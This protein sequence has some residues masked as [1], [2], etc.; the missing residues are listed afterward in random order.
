MGALKRTILYENHVKAGAN[1][2]DFGGWEMPVNYKLGMVEEHLYTRKK[3]GIFDVSHM[4]RFVI[5]GKEAVKFLQYVLTNNVFALDILRAQYT[6]ISN[7]NGGALDDA[8]LYRFYEDEYLLVVNASNIEKDWEYLNKEIVKFDAKMINKS[9]EIAMISVQGPESKNV[10][11][12]L[13]DSENFTELTKNALGFLDFKGNEVLVSR[14][15]YTGEPLGFE[16]FMQASEAGHIWEELLENGAMAIGL[17]ARDT[18]RLEAG[19]PLFG[20]ELGVD[21]YGK[22]I[23]IFSCTLAKFAVS[24]AEAK[25]DFIGR[26]AL[27]KQHEG[28][29]KIIERDFSNLSDLPRIIKPITLIDRGIARAGCNIF[30]EG[31]EVGYV[32][33]GTMVPYLKMEGTGLE[34][35]ITEEKLMRAIGL[36]LIDGD[37][38]LNDHVEVEIRGKLVKAVIPRYHLKSDTPPFARPIIF[39]R[40]S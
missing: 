16:L 27:A 23:P 39:E 33:S 17:G 10:L 30:K 25:G 22:E 14:T 1:L 29:K 32:T 4:G 3:V 36:A 19:L 2:V 21:L 40:R 8:Y 15:G 7:E 38:E 28:Y 24:F 12:S 5:S 9:E 11:L 6:M 13:S 18:L 35:K 26:K 20:H 31:K 37:I 34:T